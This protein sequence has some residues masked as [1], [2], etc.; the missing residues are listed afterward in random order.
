MKKAA[1]I[2]LV[3]LGL[4]QIAGDLAGIDAIEGVAAATGAS[5]APR[6]FSSVKGL[7]TFSSRFHVDLI[8]SGPEPTIGVEITPER[9]ARLRGPYNRRNVYGA[10]IAYAPVLPAALRDAV[11]RYGLCG[12]ALLLRELGI[13]NDP[14]RIAAI[15]VSPLPGGTFS[16]NSFRAPCR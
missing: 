15:R 4:L 1:P 9:Y 3:V 12:E 5:P 11:L 8:G 13:T 14:D 7:E 10:A 6:V 16:E 2:L